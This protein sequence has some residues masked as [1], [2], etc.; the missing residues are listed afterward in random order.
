MNPSD[1]MT[2]GEAEKALGLARKSL[3]HRITAGTIRATWFLS[4]WAI[5][6]DEVERYR[7]ENLGRLGRKKRVLI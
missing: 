7:R 1:Y 6:K 2:T 4:Q 3:S 5:S